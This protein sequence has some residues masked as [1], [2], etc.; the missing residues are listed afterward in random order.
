MYACVCVEV[1]VGVVKR[2]GVYTCVCLCVF[3]LPVCV[4]V[5]KKGCVFV[6]VFVYMALHVSGTVVGMHLCVCVCVC[7]CVRARV[8]VC[9]CACVCVATSRLWSECR[10]GTFLPYDPAT[11]IKVRRRKEIDVT[12]C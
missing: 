10:I 11:Q 2:E 3:V 12:F 6:C 4:F 8:Y 5:C 1:C 9:M 7:V